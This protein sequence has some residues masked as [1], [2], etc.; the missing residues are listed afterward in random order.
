MR[1]HGRSTPRG[2][3]GN[4][5]QT[6]RG[7]EPHQPLVHG[8]CNG[9]RR[10][11]AGGGTHHRGPRPEVGEGCHAVGQG[12]N[13]ARRRRA[14][15]A[16]R[17]Q[18]DARV[19]SVGVL[20]RRQVAAALEP[21][22]LAAAAR[23]ARRRGGAVD[24]P[25]AVT[26]RA[27]AGP[28]RTCSVPSSN[29]TAIRPASTSSPMP[30]GIVTVAGAPAASR[31]STVV[32]AGGVPPPASWPITTV[33]PTPARIAAPRPTP[34]AD[35]ALTHL[36]ISHPARSG[37]CCARSRRCRW[38]SP[39]ECR[40]GSGSRHAPRRSPST[41]APNP[42]DAAQGT[43]V[44]VHER[45]PLERRRGRSGDGV[46]PSGPT[47][48]PRSVRAAREPARPVAVEG[49]G[50]RHAGPREHERGG[51]NHGRASSASPAYRLCTSKTP[52]GH[53][54][55]LRARSTALRE[56]GVRETRD[57]DTPHSCRASPLQE[58]CQP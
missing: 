8:Q 11:A 25:D 18:G 48:A 23:A 37:G 50:K 9:D 43:A 33:A 54:R 49:V 41:R 20:A 35:R 13:G 57:V 19:G 36:G 4:R 1:C 55:A 46:A 44:R 56:A 53:V 16:R 39:S 5:V 38:G 24:R 52:G 30:G 27:A 34:T 58:W 3:D 12:Q 45:R 26:S 32:S 10:A 15:D 21:R 28:I 22:G 42:S 31:T 40:R 47:S 51:G 2:R 29:V 7:Q 6:H 17:E 14:R